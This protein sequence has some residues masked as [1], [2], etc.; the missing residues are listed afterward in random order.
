VSKRNRTARPRPAGGRTSSHAV[1][2]HAVSTQ[3]RA[4]LVAATA[5][6]GLVA[7]GGVVFLTQTGPGS[8][9]VAA[10]DGALP[11]AE[12]PEPG[13]VHVHGLGVDPADGELYAATHSGLFRL[14]ED[15]SAATRVANRYQDTMGFTVVG[16]NTFLGSGHPDFREDNPPR[17]GLVESTDAGQTWQPVSLRGEADFHAL[18]AAH[19]RVYGYEA[20]SGQFLVSPDR[21]TWEARSELPMRDFAVSPSDADTVLAT[22]ERGLARS[23]DGGRTWKAVPAPALAVL[24]WSADDSLYGVGPDGAVHHS[25]DGGTSWTER[26]SA[27]GAPEAVT[28]D[29]TEGGH[30]LYVA[31]SERG[32]LQSTDG[33][34][35]FTTRYAE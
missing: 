33:G 35:T 2:S 31:A 16:P 21:K 9:T 27:G 8:D 11:P 28:A 15:G 6:A 23:T 18:H 24:A 32:I 5:L 34:R 1:C 10:S 25:G 17:L 22:T 3:P 7:V 20:G 26:G 14:P 30:V 13:V 19:G 12:F 29:T 4:R